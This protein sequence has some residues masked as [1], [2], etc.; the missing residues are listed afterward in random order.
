MNIAS[1]QPHRHIPALDGFRGLAVLLV[2]FDHFT[3]MGGLLKGDSAFLRLLNSGYIGVDM[4][5]MLS[6]FLITGILLD[7][8]GSQNYFSAFYARRTLRIFPL[9]YFVLAVAYGTAPFLTP[10]NNL[11]FSGPNSPLWYWLYVSNFGTI[12]KGDWLLSPYWLNLGHLWSLSIE[13]QF[14]LLWPLVVFVFPQKH[15]KTA[16]LALAAMAVALRLYFLKTEGDYSLMAYLFTFARL[17]TLAIGSWIAIALRE[18]TV[19]EEVRKYRWVVFWVGG[20]LYIAVRTYWINGR[21]YEDVFAMIFFCSLLVLAIQEKGAQPWKTFLR[22]RPLVF[23][24]KYSYALYI[25]HHLLKPIFWLKLYN[26][27]LVPLL[28][29]GWA[30]V[31]AYVVI[32]TLVTIALALLSW[33]L[34]EWPLQ[35]LKKHFPYR[36]DATQTIQQ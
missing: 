10:Q 21:H 31:L 36:Y 22:S 30:G 12:V 7:T 28:G 17:N 11:D 34:L 25:Y 35:R 23:F 19:W 29:S 2:M 15:L 1:P 16:C 27:F 33:H 5:F 8:K 3:D 18:P 14:Y 9:Y 32:V 4:F 26:G 20:T 24:G 13:E 6:G